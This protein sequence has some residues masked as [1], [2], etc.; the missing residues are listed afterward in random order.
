MEGVHVVYLDVVGRT[1]LKWNFTKWQGGK[2]GLIWL[3]RV[4]GGGLL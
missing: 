2:T 3:R 1:I 4:I